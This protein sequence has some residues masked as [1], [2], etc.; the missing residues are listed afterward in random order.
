LGLSFLLLLVSGGAILATAV[1]L[2]L[3]LTAPWLYLSFKESRRTS[4]F[5]GQLPDTLQLVAGSL[6]A[7][8]AIAQAIDT[9]VRE[10]QQ[11][12][13]GDQQVGAAGRE[14]HGAGE[15]PRAAAAGT[16]HSL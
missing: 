15:Q 6:S 3:G 9:V 12:I 13:I 10:G 11:P 2:V 4:A 7:G 5:L 14:G 8:Y 1:G 16:Q